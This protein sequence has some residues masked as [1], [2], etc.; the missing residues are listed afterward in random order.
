MDTS[1]ANILQTFTLL[2]G[3]GGVI[4]AIGKAFASLMEAHAKLVVAQAAKITAEATSALAISQSQASVVSADLETKK[5]NNEA[6]NTIL[7]M[8][9]QNNTL[10]ATAVQGVTLANQ[11]LTNARDEALKIAQGGSTPESDAIL[12]VH[13]AADAH[14]ASGGQAPAPETLQAIN[15]EI[16]E[17]ISKIAPKVPNDAGVPS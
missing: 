2:V 6:W 4:F 15:A 3:S 10:A 14:V 16:D 8:L 1:I 17:Q 7:H 9:A 5:L 11:Q 13:Q 12:K